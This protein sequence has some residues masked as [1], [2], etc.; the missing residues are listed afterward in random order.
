MRCIAYFRVSTAKQGASGLGLEAQEAAV[1]DHVSRHGW[2]L[3][4]SFTEVESARKADR[5]Q[6]TRALEAC[7]RYKATLVIAKLD[8]LA[9]N[10]AFVSNLM[11][12]GTDFVAVDFPEANRLTIHILA[13]VAEHER[14]AIS[15]RTK[16][17]LQAAKARGVRLG[18]PNGAASLTR[19]GNHAAV[20]AIKTRAAA[21]RSEY[22]PLFAELNSEGHVTVAKLVMELNRRGI[23]SPRGG[24]WHAA[25]VHRVSVALRE[26]QAK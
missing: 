1:S 6:L 3:L 14:E 20:E 26:S 9:R 15:K 7:R 17:A 5:P 4:A 24:R 19:H 21:R 2:N 11:E 22:G 25:T 23:P 16:A 8:R 18:N 10:V 13:A 12:S